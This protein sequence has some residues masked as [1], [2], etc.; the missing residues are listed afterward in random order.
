MSGTRHR[1]TRPGHSCSDC[2]PTPLSRR[3][4]VYHVGALAN[5]RQ[6]LGRCVLLWWLP[7]GGPALDLTYPINEAEFHAMQAELQSRDASGAPM[8]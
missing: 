6:A 4:Y 2:Y 8:E 7:I 3:Y 1:R 5:I